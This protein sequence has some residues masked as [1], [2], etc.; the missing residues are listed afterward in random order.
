M[1]RRIGTKVWRGPLPGA[2]LYDNA[3]VRGRMGGPRRAGSAVLPLLAAATILVCGGS[4]YP[5]AY[6]SAFH[7]PTESTLR[8]TSETSDDCLLRSLSGAPPMDIFLT[9]AHVP[10]NDLTGALRTL[11]RLRGRNSAAV[12]KDASLIQQEIAKETP[13][14]TTA[15][16]AIGRARFLRLSASSL[17][18]YEIDRQLADLS[19][20]YVAAGCGPVFSQDG[21][22][23]LNNLTPLPWG[24]Y[25]KTFGIIDQRSLY[26]LPCTGPDA[27][28]LPFR[29]VLEC[30]NNIDVLNGATGVVQVSSPVF[31]DELG[32]GASLVQMSG[33]YAAWPTLIVVPAR[34]LNPPTWSVTVHVRTLMGD[35]VAN[36]VVVPSQVEQAGSPGAVFTFLGGPAGFAVGT[37]N[38]KT[39]SDT[40]TYLSPVG[41]FIGS[42]P[43]DDGEGSSVTVLSLHTFYINEMPC[44]AG[45]PGTGGLPGVYDLTT[46]RYYPPLATNVTSNTQ[47]V[48]VI[49]TVSNSCGGPILLELE[50]QYEDFA[51]ATILTDG[52]TGAMFRPIRRSKLLA[53]VASLW[54]DQLISVVGVVPA[55]VL[56]EEMGSEGVALYWLDKWD[57]SMAWSLSNQIVSRVVI[58]GGWIVAVNHS[59][60]YLFVNAATGKQ[61]VEPSGGAAAMLLSAARG[62]SLS[63]I[64]KDPTKNS[65]IVAIGDDDYARMPYI[66]VCG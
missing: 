39:N 25:G 17:L 14:P 16:E 7:S 33:Q 45:C 18:G 41:K 29:L 20:A 63:L 60:Q 35:T 62:T 42:G 37:S 9:D 57:G 28:L 27:A 36:T 5:I 66:D 65:V 11:S 64:A 48:R 49:S 22:Q 43:I 10:V 58:V 3:P 15:L 38:P 34:G 30:G 40:V 12:A 13:P 50:G 8:Q 6:S 19:V 2:D 47:P 31:P 1:A 61:S 23:Q 46:G 44:A 21:L 32:T 55:G 24:G 4:S 54:N 52:T 59:G 51:G 56:F 26:G 53:D